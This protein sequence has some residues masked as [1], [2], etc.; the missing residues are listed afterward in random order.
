MNEKQKKKQI[1]DLDVKPES[2][3]FLGSLL[4]FGWVI[5]AIMNTELDLFLLLGFLS[6]SFTVLLRIRSRKKGTLGIE[7]EGGVFGY[8]FIWFLS[9]FFY[10]NKKLDINFGIGD[11]YL[12]GHEVMNYYLVIIVIA[13][14]AITE[15]VVVQEILFGLPPFYSRLI[16]NLWKLA[17]ILELISLIALRDLKDIAN[18]FFFLSGYLDLILFYSRQLKTDFL[19]IIFDP[20][21]LIKTTLNGFFM[22]FKWFLLVLI[23]ALLGQFDIS[24]LPSLVLIAGAIF[25]GIIAEV[26]N[27]LKLVQTGGI[28]ESQIQ[29]G[30]DEV[31]RMFNEIKTFA[32][33]DKLT[34]YDEIYLIENEIKLDRKNEILSL[35]PD[36]ILLKI[37]FS[38]ELGN[39]V[40]IFAVSI[41]K[42]ILSNKS[43]SKKTG[44]WFS[45]FANEDGEIKLGKSSVNMHRFKNEEWNTIT[46][47]ITKCDIKQLSEILNVSEEELREKLVS[48]LQGVI[49]TQEFIR[50]RIRGLPDISKEN[51]YT[52]KLSTQS[53]LTLPSDILEKM[54][55]LD[56]EEIE[57]IPGKDDFLFYA[58][59]K[60]QQ[61]EEADQ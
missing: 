33:P 11:F 55:S 40:G 57:I 61:N 60:K 23:M 59:H 34:N 21:K 16:L 9:D 8:L 53:S 35:S 30:K 47:S 38:E 13:W 14:F 25:V 18:I 15:K 6:L 42:S 1:P 31:P 41:K 50:N 5:S 2:K 26:T 19:D 12:T 37:P 22:A 51:I 45:F 29:K 44:K 3:V 54:K 27:I 32:K 58:R 20:L 39:R 24:T 4:A 7:S 36:Y 49:R 28:S 48:L 10:S 17:V 52:T 43:G 56:I 46:A